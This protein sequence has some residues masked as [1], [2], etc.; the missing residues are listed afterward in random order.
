LAATIKDR[1]ETD[2]GIEIKPV[3]TEDVAGPS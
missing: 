2:S 3:Y 1:R